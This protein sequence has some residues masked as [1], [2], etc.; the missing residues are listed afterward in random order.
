ETVEVTGRDDV[1][2]EADETPF[3]RLIAAA[4][5]QLAGLAQ[6]GSRPWLLW[7]RSR[8]VPVPSVPPRESL[9]EHVRLLDRGLG[10]LQKAIE[11]ACG[12]GPLLFIVTAALGQ[13]LGETVLRTE[14]PSE[15][16]RGSRLVE[17][18]THT[19]LLIQ[20]RPGTIPGRARELV[21]TVDIG[22]TLLD[23]FGVPAADMR[24][25]GRSLLPIVRAESSTGR[26]FICLGD[27]ARQRAIRTEDFLL[28]T[29]EP[30]A[31][32][33][34]ADPPR[35]YVQPDDRWQVNDVA[36]QSPDAVGRLEGLLEGF[37]RSQAAAGK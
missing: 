14:R 11:H 20:L 19:P 17:E 1:S 15:L 12:E 24:L 34:P 18:F 32:G 16:E 28:V 21:Q 31:D 8:G 26:E 33:Q 23:W 5:E 22:P 6:S 13:S 2:M 10:R 37:L 25:D 9:I 3:A 35:L 36:G 30:P 29:D 27:G 4:D 7:L